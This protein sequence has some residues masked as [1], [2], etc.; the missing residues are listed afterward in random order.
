[1]SILTVVASQY[2]AATA[3]VTL[4]DGRVHV[5]PDSCVMTVD[6]DDEKVTFTAMDGRVY[7]YRLE[8]LL[9][10]D[11]V[12]TK[13]LPSLDSYGF[14]HDDNYQVIGNAVG[15]IA[16][17]EVLVTVAGI[18]KRLTAAFTL[19][20][21][22]ARA[23]VDGVEQ[24]SAVTRMRFDPSREYVV[25]YPGD[26]VLSPVPSGGYEMKPYGRTYTVTVDYLTDHSTS[27]PRLDINTVGGAAIASKVNYLDAAFIIDGAD[28]FPSMTDSVKVRGRGNT[29]WSS[30]PAAKNPYRLKFEEKKKPFGLRKGKNWVLI[31]N[32]IYG[33]MLTNAYGMKAASLIGA[34]AAN[35]IIPVDLYV[36]GTYK[37]NY[38]FTEKVG[39]HNNSVDLDD[40]SA[41]AMLELDRY[42]DEATGQKFKSTPRSMPV[43]IKFPEFAEDS[44]TITLNDI[45]TRFNSFVAAV[46][47]G[48]DLTP[49]VDIDYLARYLLTNEL[50][51]NKEMFHPKSVFCYNENIL[52]DSSKFVFGP[53][54]D[55]DWSCGCVMALPETYFTE[56]T[57]FD[58]FNSNYNA[59]QY[60]FFS[61]LSKNKAVTRRM[62]EIW[63]V[64]MGDGLDELCEFCQDYYEYVK[65]SLTKSRTA[66]A[67]TVD[68]AE[69][70]AKAPAWFR[71]RAQLMLD[72]LWHDNLDVGDVNGDG[73]IDVAD[74]SLLINIVLGRAEMTTGVDICDMSGDGKV[75]VA[76][77]SQLINYVLGMN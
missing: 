54:W 64:F 6:S 62:Y 63:K 45:K 42:Y 25:G 26:L 61:V 29:S 20:D 34:V 35:H 17:G 30:K 57:D 69:Q 37:G 11:S 58:Y 73:K 41:A 70:S 24:E 10:V 8:D 18:G 55:L 56:L 50:L 59:D 46:M 48:E 75:D 47:N 7:A 21:F 39:M 15:R 19:S 31:A 27:V 51:C 4:N 44:T 66:Y 9:S 33:S 36:N 77:V 23:W 38:N 12:L 65:P 52:D 2:V 16:D 68:Y 28:V 43:N 14:S 40:E 3:Y 49:H 67:D 13:R 72:R 74:V 60:E 76:D 1:M 32:K 71:T 22:G 5:F 53:M